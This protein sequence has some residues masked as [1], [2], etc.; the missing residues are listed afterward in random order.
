MRESREILCAD[1]QGK[2]ASHQN[3]FLRL[4]AIDSVLTKLGAPMESHVAVSRAKESYA[5]ADETS[6]V[7]TTAN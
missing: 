1:T 3:V 2:P 4:G 7:A 6:Q 5:H